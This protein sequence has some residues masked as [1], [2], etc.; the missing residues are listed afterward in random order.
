M[1]LK[2]LAVAVLLSAACATSALAVIPKVSDRLEGE[3]AVWIF[4]EIHCIV[5]GQKINF[6]TFI[7]K[8]IITLEHVDV[9]YV[10]GV[11]F[12]EIDYVWNKD[13]NLLLVAEIYVRSTKG[14]SRFYSPIEKLLAINSMSRAWK[15]VGIDIRD[16]LTCNK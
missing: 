6:Q 15:A 7:R 10:N 5:S 3:G 9:I 12:R 14:V 8:N 4:E 11:W 2:S 1:K 13:E 16:E